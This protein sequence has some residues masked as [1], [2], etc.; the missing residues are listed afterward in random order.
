MDAIQ[1]IEILHLYICPAHNFKKHEAGQP[2]A[3]STVDV[4][5][6]ECVAGQGLRG[7]RYFGYR[8]D[9][10]GQITFFDMDV[11]D[12]LKS[13][14]GTEFPPEAM[15]RNV[16]VRGMDLAALVGAEFELGGVRMRGSE[17]CKPCFWMDEVCGEGAEE[18]LSPDCRGGLRARI[19][20]D[21]WLE[22][23]PVGLSR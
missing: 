18:F 7:D 9:Y 23:G 3:T 1:Q 6:V 20:S 13:A 14:M 22:K 12:Q 8:E 17:H 19:L 4:E 11:Y 21:G 5:R 15:R 2:G 16:L 10:K